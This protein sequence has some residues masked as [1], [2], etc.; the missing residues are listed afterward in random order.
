MGITGGEPF[1]FP[2]FVSICKSLTDNDITLWINT[3][4]SIQNRIDEFMEKIPPSMVENLLIALHLEERERKGGMERLYPNLE[5]LRSRS[6]P[7][8]LTYVLYPP[9][10][11]R[12]LM[13][14]ENFRQHGFDLTLKPFFGEF[15]GKL[16][17]DS[18]SSREKEL[19]LSSDPGA[20]RRTVLFTRGILCEAGKSLIDI[21]VNGKVYRCVSERTCLGSIQ[22]GF[23]L[24]NQ[25]RPCKAPFC[26]CFGWDLIADEQKKAK[27]EK[28]LIDKF[29]FTYRLRRYAGLLARRMKIR[30]LLPL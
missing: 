5:K 29:P 20:A 16:F 11:D 24:Y 15:N 22:Q 2:E 25:A 17:P 23:T 19:I 27:L 7:F 12:F 8:E 10:V 6:I 18:Y 4:F 30:K 9:L 14:R 26:G 1:A 3:N 21:D 13:D 28:N